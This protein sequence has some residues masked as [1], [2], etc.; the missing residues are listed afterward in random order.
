MYKDDGVSQVKSW[1][2]VILLFVVCVVLIT[3]VSL[4]DNLK[5]LID[6]LSKQLGDKNFLVIILSTYLSP[7]ILL[8]FNFGII[9][10]LIDLIALLE[11][12]KT[13]SLKQLSI[14]RKNFFF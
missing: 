1:F 9:P 7:L 11:D 13:K 10:L 3:P 5:P 14:M 8:I 12:H 6:T 4:V 2:L